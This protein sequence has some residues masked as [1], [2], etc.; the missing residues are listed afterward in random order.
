MRHIYPPA[1]CGMLVLLETCTVC[2]LN[3]PLWTIC[4][5]RAVHQQGPL[6]RR[7]SNLD[8]W[9]IKIFRVKHIELALYQTEPT[10][11]LNYEKWFQR[12]DPRSKR[13][14]IEL[15]QTKLR[16]NQTKSKLIQT[17][18]YHTCS[19]GMHLGGRSQHQKRLQSVQRQGCGLCA[20]HL[21]HHQYHH[22][23]TD[24]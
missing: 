10:S 20:H 13:L 12:F 15:D 3:H 16:T 4:Q 18:L 23:P 22:W 1:I 2:H 8:N 6:H 19:T 17:K 11:N 9:V 24:M 5:Q 14:G 7:A 21:S